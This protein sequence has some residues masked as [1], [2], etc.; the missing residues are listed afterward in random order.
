M[1]DVTIDRLVLDLPGMDAA[2]ARTLALGVA[3][4]LAGARI[5]GDHETL[6]VTVDPKAVASPANLSAHI[7]Q[8]LLQRIG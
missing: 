4:G 5:D 6:L 7:V 2:A 8:T 3:E 1:T